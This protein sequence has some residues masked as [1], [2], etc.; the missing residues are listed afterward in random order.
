MRFQDLVRRQQEERALP[1]FLEPFAVE[2]AVEDDAGEQC[3]GPQQIERHEHD[4][5]RFMYVVHD[6]VRGA[7]PA[8]ESHEDQT[9]GIE[10]GEHRG[11]DEHGKGET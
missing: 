11:D 8:E 6:L 1:E 9:P 4:V 2:I 10:A 7:R 3:A 5:R